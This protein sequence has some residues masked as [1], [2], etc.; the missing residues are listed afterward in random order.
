[1]AA[2]R[3]PGDAVRGRAHRLVAAG[4]GVEQAAPFGVDAGWVLAISLVEVGNVAR[5]DEVQLVERIGRPFGVGHVALK[6]TV[7]TL[8]LARAPALT[9]RAA[10]RPLGLAT[11]ED[12]PQQ[13]HDPDP[14][15]HHRQ[16]PLGKR[17]PIA[18]DPDHAFEEEE[19]DARRWRGRRAGPR[20]RCERR[21]RYRCARPTGPVP[22]RWQPG[23]RAPTRRPSS[24]N[25]RSDPGRGA[26]ARR[27]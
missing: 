2:A 4:A 17:Q 13:H 26:P 9:D 27:W 3:R 22:V 16:Q 21:R 6:D 1:M 5:V 12:S 20:S 24:P 19:P 14:D 8:D 10:L 18:A 25:G 11:L 23:R 7:R 15:H